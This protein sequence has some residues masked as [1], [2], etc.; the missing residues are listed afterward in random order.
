MAINIYDIH[1]NPISKESFRCI[2]L[3]DES[4]KMH[5]IVQPKGYVPLEHIHLNQDEIFHIQSGEIRIVVEGKEIIGRAGDTI[6]VPKGAK[7]I[8]YNN[9]AEVLDA[10]C[11]YR[12][13]L[14]MQ[15]F[16]QV[17]LGLINDGYIDKKGSVIIPMMGYMLK[18]MKCRSM[19]RPVS[20]P[21]PMFN[22]ALIFFYVLG[23]IKGWEKLY[24]K[25]TGD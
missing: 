2:S 22:V 4:Y 16:E 9:S 14:D 15:K 13:A 10:I 21:A 1:I 19:A 23:G 7:H 20:I 17:F 8:A 6:T 3:T 18:K 25:Y 24:K 11:E 12:S 5:W